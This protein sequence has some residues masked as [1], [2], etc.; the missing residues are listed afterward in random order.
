M[1]RQNQLLFFASTILAALVAQPAKAAD[2]T[3]HPRVTVD[4]RQLRSDGG[5]TLVRLPQPTGDPAQWITLADFPTELS[6]PNQRAWISLIATIA[7]DGNLSHCTGRTDALDSIHPADTRY[8]YT[9]KVCSLIGKRA[10]FL[11]A[12]TAQGI[13][14]EGTIRI[15][16]DF[17]MVAPKSISPGGLASMV[18]PPPPFQKWPPRFPTYGIVVE[19]LSDIAKATP[20]KVRLGWTGEL[21]LELDINDGGKVQGCTVLQ[22]SGTPAIDA[23]SCKGLF[24][25]KLTIPRP[26][27]YRKGHNPLPVLVRWSDGEAKAWPALKRPQ[28]ARINDAAWGGLQKAMQAA[29][30]G[31]K[32]MPNEIELAVT[33]E[34]KNSECYVLASSGEDSLDADICRLAMQGTD[35]VSP[36]LDI[37]GLPQAD[38]VVGPTFDWK[39]ATPAP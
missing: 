29:H 2:P 7:A 24:K 31:A 1:I 27:P 6:Q 34:G 21:G 23:A 19:S 12:L 13:R 26:N 28:P 5:P 17:E 4:V 15:H 33:A 22:S 10:K 14:Q 36:A 37:F 38:R 9:S 25:S 39:N 35:L 32:K 8:D 20:K 30:P 18:A 16:V 11:P 3:P